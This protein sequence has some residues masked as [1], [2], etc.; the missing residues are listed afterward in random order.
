MYLGLDLGTSAVKAV[1]L[2]DA[3]RVVDRASAP[4]AVSRP[5]PLWSEQDP[6]DWWRAT[7]AA[8]CGLEAGA[9]RA[10]RAV[11][12]SG[13]MHG[14]TLLDACDRPL[15]HA[16]LWN[17]GRSA[18]ACKTL[19]AR[20]PESRR[21]TGNRA[22]PGFTAPKLVWV[23]EHEPE[24]F[25]RIRRVLLPKDYV[26]LRMTGEAATDCSDASGTLWLDVAARRWSEAMLAACDL[27]REAMPALYEGPEITGAL[28]PAVAEAW[29]LSPAPVVAGA[30]DQAAGAAGAGV[31][32]PGRASL[33]L[34]TSGVLFVADDRFRPHP[35]RAAHAF[36]HCLPGTWHQMGVIL[37]AASCLAW[38]V[39]ATGA[40]DE[41]RL[42]AEVEAA[43]RPSESL[44]F[45]PY[46]AGERT[47]HDDPEATGAFVGI[48]HDTDRAALARAVL[49]G[50]AF[51]LADAQAVLVE[52]GAHID[53]V[54]V[55]GGGARS[56]LWGRILAS[57]LDRPLRYRAGADV[58]PAL[59]AAR[60]ARLGAG[61][62]V[63]ETVFAQPPVSHE[64]RPDPGLRD[65]YAERLGAFRE[66][67]TRL[68]RMP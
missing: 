53:E 68:R 8:V 11:G 42:L 10:V 28:R 13:Q 65:H 29:G 3:D 51:A 33:A 41:T 46:L 12:L 58:G 44:L 48:T 20:I 50:V 54:S 18:T 35:E 23:R 25:G 52:A 61:E 14:A 6:E 9:R 43:D 60:L 40:P 32:V 66:L 55:I 7:G 64:A 63:P 22:M 1:L 59:G 36:C 37:S 26:R 2:D 31:V 38:V 4:L 67:Y 5:R 62:G 24:L 19:E 34:G 27:P 47:P 49:E 30:G 57:V 56:P 45:L 39:Q 21:I 16:I 17:D 15:R